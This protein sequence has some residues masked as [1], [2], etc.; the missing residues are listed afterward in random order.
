M[1]LLNVEEF[2]LAVDEEDTYTAPPALLVLL[3]KVEEL[4]LTVEWLTAANIVLY[5]IY[6]APPALLVLLLNVEK[7]TLTADYVIYLYG[8]SSLTARVVAE[9]RGVHADCRLNNPYLYG[10][11]SSLTARVVAERRGVHADCRHRTRF[12][13]LLLLLL[14][15]CSCCC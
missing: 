5:Y 10:S 4:T 3:L 8:S 6:N 15:D 11:S 14:L 13:R 12:I 2:T 1:L 7:F 9:R